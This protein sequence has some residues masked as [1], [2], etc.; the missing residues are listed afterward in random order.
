MDENVSPWI[1]EALRTPSQTKVQ[2]A[3]SGHNII[4][5]FPKCDKRKILK[6]AKEKTKNFIQTWRQKKNIFQTEM[7]IILG[8]LHYSEC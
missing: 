6:V 1:Q 5:L 2:K 8:N 3:S 4:K 7:K